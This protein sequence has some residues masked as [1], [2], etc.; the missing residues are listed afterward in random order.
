LSISPF[1][2]VAQKL[3]NFK[4]ARRYLFVFLP[5]WE[6]FSDVLEA[7]SP[8]VLAILLAR[9]SSFHFFQRSLRWHQRKE[10]KA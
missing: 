7:D 9:G 10:V 4:D 6:A 2:G 8:N 1:F 3:V 5:G